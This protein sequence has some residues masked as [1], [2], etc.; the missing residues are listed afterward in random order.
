MVVQHD[1]GFPRWLAF[2]RVPRKDRILCLQALADGD[3]RADFV[4]GIPC[5]ETADRFYVQLRSRSVCLVD[6]SFIDEN[7]S[8]KCCASV[9][10]HAP[11]PPLYL[12][13]VAHDRVKTH[14]GCTVRFRTRIF[15][16]RV[17]RRCN[18]RDSKS[19]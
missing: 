13:A 5:C 1:N 15:L 17:V 9:D 16:H 3:C 19:I 10:G 11:F 8:G 18:R 7:Q 14:T 12:P 2:F 4:A 6:C